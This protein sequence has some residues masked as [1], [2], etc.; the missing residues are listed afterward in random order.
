MTEISNLKYIQWR[1]IGVCD[2]GIGKKRMAKMFSRTD[3]AIITASDV[4]R[5]NWR[6]HPK[7]MKLIEKY[8]VDVAELSS[9]TNGMLKP[10]IDEIK[11]VGAIIGHD[12]TPNL[13]LESSEGKVQF[14]Q[15]SFKD[16]KK[17]KSSKKWF[18]WLKWIL[19]T[20]IA[21]IITIIVIMILNSMF[22][23]SLKNKNK[24]G[25]VCSFKTRNTV[26]ATE[27]DRI[28]KNLL[29]ELNQFP[30]W[31]TFKEARFYCRDGRFEISQN[32]I[33]LLQ[34]LLSVRYR[35]KNTSL[36]SSPNLK[37]IESCAITICDRKLPHLISLCKRLQK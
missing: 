8:A 26:Y 29:N 32:E 2:T 30:E 34:C 14:F 5:E 20:T 3:L 16:T 28:R 9:I 12:E 17:E 18:K 6:E 7:V 10:N 33:R 19:F 27:L 4:K 11:L 15:V 35:T 21:F 13:N 37:K 24:L 23:F 31:T 36:L 25:F 1:P 22:N